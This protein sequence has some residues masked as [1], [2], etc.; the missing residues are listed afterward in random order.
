MRYPSTS[1][2]TAAVLLSSAG[3]GIRTNHSLQGRHDVREQPRHG[4]REAYTSKRGELWVTA[5]STLRSGEDPPHQRAKQNHAQIAR[6]T[7]ALQRPGRT[8]AP[9]AHAVPPRATAL[10]G[11]STYWGQGR[12][13]CSPL[14]PEVWHRVTASAIGLVRRG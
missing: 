9:A 2:S 4:T 7:L 8:L 10:A 5:A 3:F 13:K 11:I 14:L 6:Q 1:A 12:T